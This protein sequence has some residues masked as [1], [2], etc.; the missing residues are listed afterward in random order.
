MEMGYLLYNKK[1]TVIFSQDHNILP[2]RSVCE[3][4]H[5]KILLRETNILEMLY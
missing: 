2:K 3:S 1:D 4:G 5:K